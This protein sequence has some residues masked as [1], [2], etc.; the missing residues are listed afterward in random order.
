MSFEHSFK[1]VFAMNAQRI[2]LSLWAFFFFALLFPNPLPAQISFER[3]YDSMGWETGSS[4]QQTFD[5]GYIIAGYRNPGSGQDVYVIKTDSL[6]DTLWTRIYGGNGTDQGC[7]IRQTQEGGYIIAG[8][9]NS[10]VLLIKTDASGDT[11]WTRTYD[12]SA[13]EIGYSVQ[14]TIPDGGYVIVGRTGSN[15]DPHIR[16]VYLVKTDSLGDTLWTKTYGYIR[17]DWGCSI[18]QTS[19]EGY[20]ITGVTTDETGVN[21][22]DVWLL[23]TDAG[24]D[25]LWTRTFGGTSNEWGNSVQQTFDGGYIITAHTSSFGPRSSNVWLIKIDSSG[26]YIWDRIFGGNKDDLGNSVQQT[27][28]GGYIIA[29]V[30]YSYVALGSDIYLIKTDEDGMV[31]IEEE[32]SEFGIRNA[33]FGLKQNQP[34]PFHKLTAISYQIPSSN[35]ASRIP[36]HVSLSIYDITGRLVETLVNQVQESGVYRVEWDS[37]TG[38]SPVQSGIYFY[39]FTASGLDESSPYIATKKMILLK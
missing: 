36:H 31:G 38:V 3:A 11:L 33:E 29:G 8:Y 39:R 13:S 28:D 10:D 15:F 21:A 37:R 30:T 23:K 27:T 18:Q 1:E 19:D 7:S 24:G 25:T 20:I 14:Q 4:V 32:K 12:G 9:T 17:G 5:G 6:G 34:N 22:M 35:P 2:I 16:D 26:S